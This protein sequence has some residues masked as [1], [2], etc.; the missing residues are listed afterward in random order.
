MNF[1]YYFPPLNLYNMWLTNPYIRKYD[2]EKFYYWN[3]EFKN[4]DKQID[5]NKRELTYAK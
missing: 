5:K 3:K 2:D 4:F 1:N